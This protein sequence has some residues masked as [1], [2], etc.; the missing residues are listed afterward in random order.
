M[1]AACSRMCRSKS[2]GVAVIG[3]RAVASRSLGSPG[4]AGREQARRG[5]AEAAPDVAARV[6]F[7][8]LDVLSIGAHAEFDFVISDRCLI[9]L[10][11]FQLQ[12]QAIEQIAAALKPGGT[13]VAVEN[14]IGAHESFN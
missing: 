1:S 11:S 2:S 7:E 14:F 6:R 3:R 5:L 8:E 12:E 10:P 9:N 13:Y 4:R